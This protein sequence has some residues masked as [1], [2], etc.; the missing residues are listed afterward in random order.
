MVLLLAASQFPSCMCV[1]LYCLQVRETS[2]RGWGRGRGT[3]AGSK[4][5][6]AVKRD[7]SDVVLPRS[8]HDNVRALA[9]VTANTRQ[10]GAPFRHMMFYGEL[11]CLPGV[12]LRPIA[13]SRSYS[14][15]S[16]NVR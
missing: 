4:T 3:A 6:E 2:R 16:G 13:G 15:C 5:L 10:H 14:R 8:L 9:A 11:I 1:G 7:F 12:F